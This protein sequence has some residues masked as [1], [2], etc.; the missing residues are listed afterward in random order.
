M[1]QGQATEGYNLLVGMSGVRKLQ[2]MVTVC[3]RRLTQSVRNRS[4]IG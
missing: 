2:L 4:N 1:C 3:M